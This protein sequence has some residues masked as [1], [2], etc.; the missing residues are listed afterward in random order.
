MVQPLAS[1]THTTDLAPAAVFD[2]LDEAAELR[3][4]AG[5]TRRLRSRAAQDPVLDLAGNDYLGLTRHPAVT[6][7]AAE[8]ALRWGGGRP[9]RGW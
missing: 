4:E 2:W 5:L 6:Q 1:A 7:A 8:A 9:G 3:A